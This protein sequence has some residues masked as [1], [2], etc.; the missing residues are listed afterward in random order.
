ML[1]PC[2]NEHPSV[3]AC[4]EWL[5]DKDAALVVKGCVRRGAWRHSISG[6]RRQ[7][8]QP[9]WKGSSQQQQLTSDVMAERE[10]LDTVKELPQVGRAGLVQVICSQQ[11][12]VCLLQH[13]C[14]ADLP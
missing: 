14:R 11:V 7:A 8:L 9:G 2:N 6:P 10:W 5:L 3:P 13:G 1:K 4:H 12:S